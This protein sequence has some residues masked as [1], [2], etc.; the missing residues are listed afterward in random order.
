MRV[1]K[2]GHDV[3]ADRL[4]S[5]FP[6]TLSDLKAAVAAL[7]FVWVFDNQDLRRPYRKVGVFESGRRV[8][9]APRPPAWLAAIVKGPR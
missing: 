7:P 3:P 2:G 1:S 5:R 9:L 8:F 6:R 4:V